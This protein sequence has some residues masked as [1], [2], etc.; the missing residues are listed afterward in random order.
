MDQFM[1]HTNYRMQ[2]SIQCR[3]VAT[4]F[5]FLKSTY[6][7]YVFNCTQFCGTFFISSCGLRAL[8]SDERKTAE[9]ESRE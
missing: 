4:Q 1:M 2:S 8:W 7:C 3:C 9:R 5:Y 6:L